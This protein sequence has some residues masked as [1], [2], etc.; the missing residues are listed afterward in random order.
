MIHSHQLP[1]P[2]PIAPR[3]ISRTFRNLGLIVQKEAVFAVQNVLKDES[4]PTLAM[5]YI[6]NAITKK[7]EIEHP[8]SRNPKKRKDAGNILVRNCH[9]LAA[10]E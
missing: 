8:G 1:P 2:E 7:I 6:L 5:E 10:F 4:D 9:T 3:E